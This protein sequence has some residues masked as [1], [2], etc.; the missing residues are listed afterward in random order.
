[1]GS[2]LVRELKPG[3][4]ASCDCALQKLRRQAVNRKPL[5]AGRPQ[6]GAGAGRSGSATRQQI[7]ALSP[8]SDYQQRNTIR[9]LAT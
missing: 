6:P 3:F 2:I 7:F 4:R 1:M 5:H 9:T 8:L